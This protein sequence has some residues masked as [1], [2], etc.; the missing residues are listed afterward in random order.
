MFIDSD[1]KSESR[2]G[3]EEKALASKNFETETG[4]VF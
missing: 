1:Y 2:M 4:F 3:Q